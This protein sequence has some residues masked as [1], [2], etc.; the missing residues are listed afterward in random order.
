M[1]IKEMQEIEKLN[2]K[3]YTPSYK[4]IFK[5]MTY[6]GIKPFKYMISNYGR[7]LNCKSQKIMKTYFDSD[8]YE[9]I[10]LVTNIK[11]QERRGNK[12]KH[13]F[14]SSFDTLGI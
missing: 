8:D 14:Y 5:Y 4:E 13:F 11:H 7:V 2:Y 6:P 10:T 12:P 9:K 1:V 3:Y